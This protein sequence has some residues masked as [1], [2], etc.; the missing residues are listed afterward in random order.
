MAFAESQDECLIIS[1]SLPS[2][3][4]RW[5]ATSSLA[6]ASC[7]ARLLGPSSLDRE[8]EAEEGKASLALCRDCCSNKAGY[9]VSGKASRALGCSVGQLDCSATEE[10]KS[11]RLSA[12]GGV[13]LALS[14]GVVKGRAAHSQTLIKAKRGLE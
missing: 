7:R 8:R 4:G 13:C 10:I 9:A 6:A 2:S 12:S 5:E 11:Y 14:L 3:L 1:L